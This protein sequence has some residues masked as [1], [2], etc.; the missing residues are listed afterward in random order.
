MNTELNELIR[1]LEL[2]G[3]WDEIDILIT[4]IQELT[5]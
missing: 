5:K 3:D 4:K 2:S 1:K